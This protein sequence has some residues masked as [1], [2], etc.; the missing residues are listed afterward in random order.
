MVAQNSDRDPKEYLPILNELKRMKPAL[1]QHYHIDSL[2]GDWES[3]LRHLSDL[4]AFSDTGEP[5][6]VEEGLGE[7]QAH[8]LEQCQQLISQH[9]LYSKAL[10]YFPM[11]RHASHIS[12]VEF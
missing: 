12:K 11:G 5:M 4:L 2:L 6:K 10:L 3:A 7:S 1:Y 9:K 8:I